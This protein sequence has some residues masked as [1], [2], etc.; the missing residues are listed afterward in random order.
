MAI[1]LIQRWLAFLEATW[2][3][4]C[5]L[6]CGVQ[7]VRSTTILVQSLGGGEVGVLFLL[8]VR[9]ILKL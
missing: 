2:L 3:F 5:F 8:T 7:P 4:S 1:L 9:L 6:S